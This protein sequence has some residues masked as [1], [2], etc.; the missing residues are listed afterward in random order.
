MLAVAL[1]VNVDAVA[2]GTRLVERNHALLAEDGIHQSGLADVGPADNGQFRRSLIGGFFFGFK[3]EILQ[4]NLDHFAHVV[5]VRRGDRQRFA[6]AQFEKIGGYL[7]ALHPLCLVDQQQDRLAGLAQLPSNDGVLRRA[8]G[9]AVD[10][11]Q[12]HVG[13]VHRLAALLGHFV[14]DAIL[15]DRLQPAGIHHQIR[16]VAHSAA[17]VMAVARQ[18]GLVSDQRVAAAREAVEQGGLTHVRTTY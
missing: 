11:E 8:P 2:R 5:A 3:R 9:A 6:Q 14:Q 1:E 10:Q 12:H 16:P 18:P 15:G 17:P 7:G 4:R 13:L